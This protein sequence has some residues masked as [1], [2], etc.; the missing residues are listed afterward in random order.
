MVLLGA[1]SQCPE[2]DT[3]TNANPDIRT[4]FTPGSDCENNIIAELNKAHK[5]EISVYS[6]TNTNIG[7]AIFDAHKRGAQIRIITDRLMSSNKYSL[8]DEFA[9]AGIPVLI[10]KKKDK[11]INP[12]PI[13]IHHNKFAIFDDNMVVSGSYNWTK[14]ASE[15]NSEDCSFF[16][17][18]SSKQF[19]N[20]F[21]E[22]WEK[23]GVKYESILNK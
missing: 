10:N 23:N 15:S 19:S 6:I 5:I 16:E 14:N 2:N 22:M 3:A 18:P 20:R 9:A 8:A 1:C 11:K 13:K 7:N 12:K 17:Q 4:Y 21:E